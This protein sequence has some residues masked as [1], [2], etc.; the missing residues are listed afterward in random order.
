MSLSLVRPASADTRLRPQG[1]MNLAKEGNFADRRASGYP[2][3]LWI[4]LL[5]NARA[6]NGT[7]H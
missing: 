7:Q 4:T 6:P 2:P 1:D 5:A 3:P